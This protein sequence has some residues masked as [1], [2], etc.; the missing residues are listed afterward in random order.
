MINLTQYTK[1]NTSITLAKNKK[2]NPPKLFGKIEPSP[3]INAPI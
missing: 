3:S 1:I 2:E